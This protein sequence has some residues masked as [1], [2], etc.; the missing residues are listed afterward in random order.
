MCSASKPNHLVLVSALLLGACVVNPHLEDG[1]SVPVAETQPKEQAEPVIAKATPQPISAADSEIKPRHPRN[2]SAWKDLR[3]N[4]KLPLPKSGQLDSYLE[5][6]RDQSWSVQTLLRRSEPYLAWIAQ[7]TKRQGVPGEIALLPAVES[8]FDPLAQSSG[9]AV[10]LW[11]FIPA[12][13]RRFG[14]SQNWWYDGRRDVIK[15]TKAALRYL[16]Y[17]HQRFDGDW[18]LALAAYNTGE[19][20]IRAAVKR[21]RSNGK[22]TD[23]WH[24]TLPKETQD[25]VPRLL[26][27]RVVV[28]HPR[29]YGVTLPD[30]DNQPILTVTDTGGQLELAVAAKLAGLPASTL[31][32][33]NPGYK[34]GVTPPRGPHEIVLPADRV[35]RFQTQL[36]SLVPEQ[37]VNRQEHHVQSGET[38]SHIALRYHTTVAAL[39]A[40]NG[41]TNDR[42]RTGTTLA[43]PGSRRHTGEYVLASGGAEKHWWQRITKRTKKV[44]HGVQPGDTL[45]DLARHYGV[46]VSQLASWNRISANDY[47]RPGQ[48]LVLHMQ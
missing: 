7:E 19:G 27:L 16:K 29:R 6:Y 14:L 22:P 1:M 47:L 17:L 24:L 15:S 40:T 33:L 32:Y 30:I 9:D 38:L 2:R 28:E 44:V 48:K 23:F 10:G 31:Y 43:V 46:S 25:Y 42:I 34:R 45:W 35:T 41:L 18:L 4:F 37:R 11:Q 5:T 39:R 12:T 13:G 26:A 8:G 21:N 36:A 3:R 20:K